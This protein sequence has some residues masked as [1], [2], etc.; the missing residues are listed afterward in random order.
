MR[1]PPRPAP[2][3]P[4]T[5]FFTRR[6]KAPDWSCSPR[7]APGRDGFNGFSLSLDLATLD[8]AKRPYDA[9]SAGG[10]AEMPVQSAFWGRHFGM[11][12]DKFGVNW[13]LVAE[14]TAPA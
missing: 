4:A 3:D 12:T 13:M 14:H 1:P 9:L 7:I 11:L 5:A 2:R 10:V 6:S 8:E